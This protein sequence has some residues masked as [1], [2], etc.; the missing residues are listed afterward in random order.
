[1]GQEKRALVISA[2]SAL[3]LGILALVAGIQTGSGAILLDAAFNICFFGTA[4]VTL[5]VAALLKRPDDARYPFGYFHFEPLINL[6]KGLLIVGTG[7]AAT[8][9]AALNIVRGGNDIAEGLALAYAVIGSLVCVLTLAV[10]V[11][12]ARR[13]QSLLVKGDVANWIVNLAITVG[14]G[15]A[16]Y[17]AGHLSR[18]A[19]DG[20]AGY[21]DPV[22]VCLVVALTMALPVRLGA[23]SLFALLRRGSEGA[24]ATEIHAAVAEEM[25]DLGA[26]V[27]VRV[28]R[29]GR[30][31]YALVHV[32]L[33]PERV[34]DVAEADRRR[35]AVQA[36]LK[37]QFGGILV[38]VLFTLDPKLA[39]PVVVDGE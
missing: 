23:Q 31:I 28:V 5:R 33:A 34:L 25:G 17:L 16:F 18:A 19:L 32:V 11:P 1:M 2:V 12:I 10:L 7:L 6:I 30:V 20:P 27:I 3:G 36:S 35:A 15:V 8:F 24:L 29:P 26:E 39:S 38:D 22:L 21:V 14:M 37:A 4:L 9:D 13:T